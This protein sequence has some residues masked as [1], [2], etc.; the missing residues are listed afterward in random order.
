MTLIYILGLGAALI[1]WIAVARSNRR[2]EYFAKPAVMLILIFGLILYGEIL[3][4]PI[5]W[6]FLAGLG[7]SLLG[8]VFLML[9]ANRFIPG[10]LAFLAAHL[11]Y[12]VAFNQ[13]GPVVSPASAAFA[14]LV[15]GIA[16]PILVRIRRALLL[17]GRAKLWPPVAVYGV[18]LAATLWST[19]CTTLRP[20]WPWAGALLAAIGGGLFFVSDALN[21]WERFVDR[22]TASRLLVMVSYHL[23]QYLMAAGVVLAVAAGAG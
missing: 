8:D 18:V 17:A 15:A 3:P 2:L 21:A 1:D 12:V 22:F 7:F 4:S 23:A 13:G 14:L 19:W 20:E 10:L 9:P 16:V 5:G 11:L 6:L